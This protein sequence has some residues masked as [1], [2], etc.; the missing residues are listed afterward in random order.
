MAPGMNLVK[1]LRLKGEYRINVVFGE[2]TIVS[3]IAS[4][5]P[6]NDVVWSLFCKKR[7][8]TIIIINSNDESL[9]ILYVL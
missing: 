3:I 8:E 2:M 5:S 6:K 1:P 7:S 4:F 9:F